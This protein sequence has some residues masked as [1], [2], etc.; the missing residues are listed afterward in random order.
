MSHVS[1][2]KTKIRKPNPQLLKKACE[3]TAEELK[4]QIVDTKVASGRWV[5]V[6]GDIIM[7]KGSE[8]IAIVMG[9]EGLEVQGDTYV[10]GNLLNE[11]RDTLQKNYIGLAIMHSA[12]RAGFR[13]AQTQLDKEK[14]VGVMVRG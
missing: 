10:L 2:A 3:I 6:R 7:M 9:E 13:V 4:L 12:M 8:P 14:L 11:V 1:R 5:R